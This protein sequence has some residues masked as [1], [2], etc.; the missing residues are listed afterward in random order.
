MAGGDAGGALTGSRV[1]PASLPLRSPVVAEP[2][3][4]TRNSTAGTRYRERMASHVVQSSFI[5]AIP[6]L[7]ELGGH[8]VRSS[9]RPPRSPAREL[10]VRTA[11]PPA[12]PGPRPAPG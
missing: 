4:P 9:G 7:A 5:I 1:Q 11:S 10:P 2:R 8:W 3:R 12:G 6:G